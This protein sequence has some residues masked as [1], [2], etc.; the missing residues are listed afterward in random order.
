MILGSLIAGTL[1]N[2]LHNIDPTKKRLL[3][4]VG[5]LLHVFNTLVILYDH[6]D[7]FLGA[8]SFNSNTKN[9]SRSWC[10]NITLSIV[11]FYDDY[12]EREVLGLD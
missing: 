4:L 12:S 11:F 10:W 3:F 5:N 6:L 1:V 7:I 9:C 8:S 2:S